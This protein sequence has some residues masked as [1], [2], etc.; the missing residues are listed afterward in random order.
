MD[1]KKMK[2]KEETKVLL[3]IIDNAIETDFNET[4]DILRRNIK[5]DNIELN[6][7]LLQ[8]LNSLSPQMLIEKIRALPIEWKLKIKNIIQDG[9]KVK[10]WNIMTDTEQKEFKGMILKSC[11]VDIRPKFLRM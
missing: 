5:K 8:V 2:P 6:Y 10:E 9:Q 11:L 1:F 4:W 7:C 3:K